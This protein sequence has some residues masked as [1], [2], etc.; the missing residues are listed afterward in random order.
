MKGDVEQS[1]VIGIS[2]N[3]EGNAIEISQS[4]FYRVT[5]L[6]VIKKKQKLIMRAKYGG[7]SNVV[8]A[9]INA[10]LDSITKDLIAVVEENH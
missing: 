7:V 9:S 2:G 3:V 8:R 6:A 1:L 4:N 5:A 10:L